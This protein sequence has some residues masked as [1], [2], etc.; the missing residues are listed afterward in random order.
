MDDKQTY[1]IYERMDPMD[2]YVYKFEQNI[3]SYHIN[4]VIVQSDSRGI[5]I[6]SLFN[7]FFN[8][9]VSFQK[10]VFVKKKKKKRNI[11]NIYIL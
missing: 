8:D 3:P 9:C 11:K 2:S 6:N 7:F 4:I 10:I 1:R 5:R